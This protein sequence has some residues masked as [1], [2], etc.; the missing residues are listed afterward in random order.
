MKA[1]GL[2]IL[3]DTAIFWGSRLEPDE[4][5]GMYYIN[6]VI[7]PDEYKEH[8]NNDAYTNYMAHWCMKTAIEQYHEWKEKDPDTIS[9]LTKQLGFDRE[10]ERL[11]S[12]LDRIYLPEPDEHSIIAQEDTYLQKE[13]IDLSKYKKQEQV[14]SIFR[15]Y[16]IEQINQ[17]QVTKQASV[18]MLVYV[19]EDRFNEQIKAAN[20]Q[21]YEPKTLHDSSLS[22][23]THAVLAADVGEL[24]L[25][26]ELFRKASEIDLGPNKKSSDQGVHAASLGGIWQIVVCGFGGLRMARG[27][28]RIDPKLPSTVSSLQYPVTWRGNPLDITVSKGAITIVNKGKDPV[29]ITSGNKEYVVKKELNLK[30]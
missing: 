17:I 23:S 22:L 19:L 28:L 1:S 21:Y 27:K 4:A 26:Y 10:I 12:M 7:G 9:R 5:S 11:E 25:A 18:V 30:F 29:E 20:F 6:K 14:G 8:I 2:E 3:L 24:D 16:N 15:D 13:I